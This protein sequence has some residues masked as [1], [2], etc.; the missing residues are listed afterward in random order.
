MCSS[1]SPCPNLSLSHRIHR[2]TF[3]I[4][5]WCGVAGRSHTDIVDMV[6]KG[7][8]TL[9]LDVLRVSPEEVCVNV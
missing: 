4:W 9:V 2:L 3:N 8:S 5:V 7:G 6:I 1:P